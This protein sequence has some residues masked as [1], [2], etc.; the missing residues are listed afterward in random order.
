MIYPNIK[1]MD[2]ASVL[3]DT[4]SDLINVNTGDVLARF[5]HYIDALVDRDFHMKKHGLSKEEIKIVP[6]AKNKG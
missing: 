5:P 4:E 2:P 3:I 6:S 1:I